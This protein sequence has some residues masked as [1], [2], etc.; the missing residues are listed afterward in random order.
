MFLTLLLGI[1]V[2]AADAATVRPSVTGVE[3]ARAVHVLFGEDG[4]MVSTCVAASAGWSCSP[5]NVDGPTPVFLMVDTRVV[6]MG[7]VMPQGPDMSIEGGFDD[8]RIEWRRSVE[9]VDGRPDSVVIV[10]VEGAEADRAP[11]VHLDAG[12]LKTEVG[13][14]DD[15]RFPDGISNDGLFHCASVLQTSTLASGSW[16]L[17]VSMRNPNG[18]IDVLATVPFSEKTGLRMISV[19]VGDPEAAS[20]DFFALVGP[21]AQSLDP[22]SMNEDGTKQAPKAPEEDV[23]KPAP[24]MFSGWVWTAVLGALSIG[25]L[26][27]SRSPRGSKR[28]DQAMAIPVRP[29]DDRGPV[30]DE[31]SIL[32]S[33]AD[34]HQTLIH[35][36]KQL[37]CRRRVLVVGD[38]DC[39]S[40][41]P[42]HPVHLVTDADRF[43]VRA[44]VDDFWRDGG[45]PPVLLVLGRQSIL[46]TGGASPTPALDV[47]EAIADRTWCA[48]FVSEDES[49]VEDLAH[50]GYDPQAGWTQL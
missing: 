44:L 11:M 31:G 33:S 34:P 10:R 5:V 47:L 26:I 2:P 43:S 39:S 28:P 46:D 7:V 6:D 17:A 37:T 9:P 25:W 23:P 16:T 24:Q 22:S 41:E 35:V 30:P 1:L 21:K 14:T 36:V 38:V 4:Q 15:G 3:D 32:I 45:V 27:G 49:P 19:R 8:P 20:T 42:I 13:C 40:I 18:D 29:L 12:S 50:W 48:L